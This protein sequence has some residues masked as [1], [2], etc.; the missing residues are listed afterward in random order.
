MA[1]V[2]C[3]YAKSI[4]SQ[5]KRLKRGREERGRQE[6]RG[7]NDIFGS[8]EELDAPGE[9]DDDDRG[10]GNNRRADEFDDF[11]E[12]DSSDD[13][14]RRMGNGD[15]L[16][17][18]R[19]GGGRHVNTETLGL[20]DGAMGDMDEIFGLGDYEEALVLEPNAADL[21]ERTSE[22]QLKDV[23]E[24]SELQERLLTDEDNAIRW[25]DEPERF[26]IA[27]KPFKNLEVTPEDLADE[28]T[29][30]AN[31][32]LAKKRLDIDLEEPFFEAVRNVLRFFVV[33]NYEVPFVWHQRR[34]YVIHATKV[35][36]RHVQ[37]GE[38]RYELLS[39]RLLVEKD[40]WQILDLDLKYRAFLEKR[41][42]LKKLYDLLITKVGIEEDPIVEER[43]RSGNMIE[44]M[45]DLL[46]YVHFRYQSQ[47]KEVQTMDG[48][49]Q[50]HRRPGVGKTA[51]E[52]IR[53]GKVY[54][55][56]K[57]F[58]L[59]ADQF[60]INVQVGKKREFAD[61]PDRIPQE[62]ADDFVDYPDFPTGEQAMLAAK[63][64][65]AEEIYMNPRMRLALRARWFTESVV[66]VN[67]TEKGVKAIDDQHQYYE[68]KYLKNQELPAIAT[69]PARYLKMLKA[70][71]DGL[72]EIV[73]ELRDSGRLMREMYEYIASDNYSE[74]AEAWNR[75]RK[76]VVDMAMKKITAM[77][78]KQLRDELRN[79]CEDDIA[80]EIT[81]IFAKV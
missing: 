30:I 11:I 20:R 80:S 44:Q 72:I 34:D 56:V 23:F 29:W 43:I 45:Q 7:L 9:L 60:A 66:H 37:D 21:E 48:A 32:L 14:D 22:L 39:E 64:M 40:L 65:L 71:S 73:Y 78:Q 51:F 31:T 25:Q 41:N 63:T 42:G 55:L 26:Q 15:E 10:Y 38:P 28:G 24:P 16:I 17:S 79:A 46:D 53:Q 33:D 6:S 27:R 8:D 18:R 67:V 57:A 62:M 36:R 47:V 4:Q 2:T 70:E 50:G 81:R 35:P 58:G 19:R 54:G 1:S 74:V 52:R 12:N 77:F 5:F 75:E 3:T 61:D 69:N 49:R 59:T 13:E 76:D 68:F